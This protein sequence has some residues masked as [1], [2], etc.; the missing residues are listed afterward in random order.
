MEANEA[1]KTKIARVPRRLLREQAVS[2]D[3]SVQQ[4][5]RSNEFLLRLR[6]ARRGKVYR[7]QLFALGVLVLLCNAARRKQRDDASGY[8][9]GS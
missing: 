8:G 6:I 9:S 4:S 3:Q 5:H 2:S 7:P 1:R